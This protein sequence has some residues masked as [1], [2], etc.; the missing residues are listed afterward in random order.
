MVVLPLNGSGSLFAVN[1]E[2]SSEAF[3]EKYLSV[4][5]ISTIQTPW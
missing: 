1:Y 2:E 5:K 4:V 3:K